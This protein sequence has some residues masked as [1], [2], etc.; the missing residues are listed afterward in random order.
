MSLM[1]ERGKKT[2]LSVGVVKI[3][4]KTV[5]CPRVS[6]VVDGNGLNDAGCNSLFHWTPCRDRTSG[7][8][9]HFRIEKHVSTFC[10]KIYDFKS[11]TL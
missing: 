6:G 3:P 7:C 4:T 9:C 10:I 1:T 5:T 11:V 8:Q 2:I